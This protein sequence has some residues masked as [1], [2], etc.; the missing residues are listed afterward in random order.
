LDA[1]AIERERDVILRE[2]EEVDKI[3]EEVTFDHLHA[4]AFQ[5]HSLGKTI[6]GPRENILGL[7]KD[8]LAGYIK[9]NYTA[10]RMVLVGAGGVDHDSLV[11]LAEKEFGALK[12]SS[13]SAASF[14][15][16]DLVPRFFGSEVRVR[17][18]TMPT[19][20]IALAVEGVGWTHP[21]YYPLLVLQS[22][23]GS[24]DRSLGAATHVSSPHLVKNIVE[25]QLANSYMSFNTSYRD[26]GLWGIYLVSENKMHLDDLEFVV[27]QEWNR[28]SN[29]LQQAEVV[30]AK[31]GLKSA[32]ILGLDGGT[33]IAED[34]GRQLVCG[35]GRRVEP[36][37]VG[38]LI[39]NV[40]LSDVTRVAK[41]YLWDREVAV[42]GV[43]PVE[44][45]ADY[46]RIRGWMSWNRL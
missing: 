3:M 12:S 45:M 11:K 39:D 30:R 38:Q 28:C 5:D 32:M 41:E 14:P 40:S 6:L 25:N 29:S 34:I 20:H 22:I 1:G 42:V 46:Q 8:D 36:T 26:T 7:Q 24:W 31:Q 44:S 21:D 35:Y 10:D 27:Q 9:Q 33:A 16:K 2:Q 17:N 37:E 19:A 18:D 23:I 43:G 15:V 4:M 13:E